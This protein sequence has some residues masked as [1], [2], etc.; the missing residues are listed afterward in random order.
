MKN[1]RECQDQTILFSGFTVFWKLSLS[2][3]NSSLQLRT[4]GKTLVD[5]TVCV[6]LFLSSFSNSYVVWESTVVNFCLVTYLVGQ[7]WLLR[8]PSSEPSRV[9]SIKIRPTSSRSARLTLIVLFLCGLV[10]F[11]VALGSWGKE[12]IKSHCYFLLLLGEVEQR[13]LPVQ[14]GAGLTL[15]YYICIS[16]AGA[17]LLLPLL[18]WRLETCASAAYFHSFPQSPH[19]EQTEHH[20]PLGTLPSTPDYAS[21]KHYRF[22]TTVVAA[23]ASVIALWQW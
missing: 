23:I 18:Q 11:K 13:L 17:F 21:Y 16:S 10:R 6:L 7:L 3:S 1:G 8:R 14:R 20:K 12:P 22:G 15:Y 5:L 2:A 4:N 9:A 19:C